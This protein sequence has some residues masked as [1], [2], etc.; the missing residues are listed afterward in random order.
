LIIELSRFVVKRDTV[1]RLLIAAIPCPQSGT[2]QRESAV[3]ALVAKH[4]P[5][6]AVRSAERKARQRRIA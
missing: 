3:S 5:R 4:E 2:P 6:S 1:S